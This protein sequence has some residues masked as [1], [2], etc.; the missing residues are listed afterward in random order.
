MYRECAR[1]YDYIN[2]QC[3]VRCIH[4]ML[5]DIKSRRSFI[6]RGTISV[7]RVYD[8]MQESKRRRLME[9]F[10]TR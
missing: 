8:E 2:L 10:I 3:H 7:G 9:I 5:R 1:V 4:H 6:E